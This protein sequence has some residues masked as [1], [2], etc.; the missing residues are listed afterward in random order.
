MFLSARAQKIGEK[1]GTGR[2]KIR[3]YSQERG[4]SKSRACYAEPDLLG[5]VEPRL[6]ERLEEV[7][8][9]GDN[10]N[11]ST[12]RLPVRIR[13]PVLLGRV[14]VRLS[15]P[16]DQRPKNG[17]HAFDQRGVLLIRFVLIQEALELLTGS[18]FSCQLRCGRPPRAS[19]SVSDFWS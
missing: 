14:L 12:Q 1:R 6:P 13:L 8:E 18:F 2:Q 19:I 11:L 5:H 9:L 15:Y 16:E 17:F 3:R 4:I 10:P 7:E